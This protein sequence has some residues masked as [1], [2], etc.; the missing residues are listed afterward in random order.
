MSKGFETRTSAGTAVGDNE[1]ARATK[2]VSS[3][4]SK[5]AQAGGLSLADIERR[6]NERLQGHK[7]DAMRTIERSISDL[8][9]LA[10]E[11]L[12][13]FD[14]LYR[15]ASAVLSVAGFFDTGPLYDAVYSLC[16]TIEA[17]R[18][19]TAWKNEAVHVHVRG[20]RLIMNT[21][22]VHSAASEQLMAGLKAIQEHAK[23]A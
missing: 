9:V 19:R 7:H 14:A 3:L 1:N 5:M 6:A 11:D 20:I 12:Q 2:V 13:D 15:A 16:E 18:E 22:C 8:E 17:M 4:S 10:N 23:T 21:G